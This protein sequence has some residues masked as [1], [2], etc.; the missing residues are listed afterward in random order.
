M[1]LQSRQVR[2]ER[3]VLGKG[4]WGPQ[5]RSSTLL[6]AC[7][8]SLISRAHKQPFL[9]SFLKT[10][11]GRRPGVITAQRPK[12]NKTLSQNLEPESKMTLP[13]AQKTLPVPVS[14]CPNPGAAVSHP[15]AKP[16]RTPGSKGQG[17]VRISGPQLCRQRRFLNEII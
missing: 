1:C 16:A 9:P 8:P 5:D 4:A 13:L 11:A 15:H 17:L 12:A 6:H 10:A 7:L 14:T 2:V 3:P